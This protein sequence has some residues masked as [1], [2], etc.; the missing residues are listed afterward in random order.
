MKK[1]SPLIIKSLSGR[2]GRPL[3]LRAH[4]NRGGEVTESL[5]ISGVPA[6][7]KISEAFDR[8][9]LRWL[10]MGLAGV[11]LIL[12]WQLTRLQLVN[13]ERLAGLAEGNRLRQ[14]VTYAPRGRIF[15]RHGRELVSNTATFQLVVYPY[16]LPKSEAE[17]G[18]IYA[19][20]A[21]LLKLSTNDVQKQ[22]E[23]KG[24]EFVQPQLL[25]ENIGYDLALV[26]E[27]KLPRLPGLTLDEIPIRHYRDD[28]ALS[29]VLGYVG[30]VDQ[31]DLSQRPDLSAID[32]VGQDGIEAVYDRLLRGQN[33]VVETEVDAAGRPLRVLRDV[34]TRP[35][36]D[37]TLTLDYELQQQLVAALTTEM[38]RAAVVRAS[39]VAIDPKSGEVL[40][41]ASLPAYDNNK[42]ARGIS[43]ADYQRLI[44]D[45]AQPLHNKAI[46]GGYPSGSIIKPMHLAGALEAG[47]V[48]EQTTI[49]DRGKIVVPSVYD[50]SVNYTFLGWNLAGLGPMNAR[51]AIAMSSDIYFYTVGGGYQGFQG[52]GVDRLTGYYRQFGLGEATGIDLPGET[53]GRV[54]TPE[55]KQQNRGE[56]W[57]VG[58]T[59]N[60][61]IGQG[62][63]LASP[64]QMAVATGAVVNGGSLLKPHIFK[65]TT[66]GDIQKSAE[67]IRA[68]FIRPEHLNVVREGMRQVIG[69]TTSTATFARVPVPVAGKSGTAETDPDSRRRAHAWYTAFAPFD[70]P[71]I[72][73]AVI[74]EEGEGGSQFAAPVI[75]RAMEWYF[76]H[77]KP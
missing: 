7:G 24:L 23:A 15:D 42:F 66:A 36:T 77:P 58:D 40:A 65:Q 74:L 47:V 57:F 32:F 54:P 16:L 63:L 22:A 73:F 25:S 29:H 33:G 37:I 31:Q 52:L 38:K 2:G 51:R 53:A 68:D 45:P 26:L 9:P 20:V 72:L 39:A 71:Q 3:R 61:S 50:P 8:R 46:G 49:V 59:Y 67:A 19:D 30:R 28:A 69:G 10:I 34:A 4:G 17:R 64:L 56:D 18:Q 76:T 48:N 60:I 43:Q 14:K 62:D 12:I 1:P 55:W 21:S 35:G 11:G 27:Q 41:M 75:A 5:L 70:E 6:A 13:G 44:N